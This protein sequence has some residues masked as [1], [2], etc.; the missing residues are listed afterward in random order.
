MNE[1]YFVIGNKDRSIFFKSS[2]LDKSKPIGDFYLFTSI[3]EALFHGYLPCKK[4]NPMYCED[5]PLF[6]KKFFDKEEKND[7]EEVD[8]WMRKEHDISLQDYLQFIK[9]NQASPASCRIKYF[10]KEV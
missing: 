7:I 5:A 8:L 2:K 6:V 9:I 1:K 10:E 3:K 4:C